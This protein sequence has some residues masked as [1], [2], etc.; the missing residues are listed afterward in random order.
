MFARSALTLAC[1]AGILAVGSL[2]VAPRDAAAEVGRIE[3]TPEFIQQVNA[4]IDRGVAFLRKAQLRE[5]GWPAY[6]GYGPA[7]TAFAYHTMRACGVPAT[8]PALERG[9][10]ALRDEWNG[11]PPPLRQTYTIALVMMAVAEHGRRQPTPDGERTTALEPADEAW[12]REMVATLERRQ[13]Q[14]GTWGYL[15]ASSRAD[16]TDNSNTQ[17]ALL[18]LKAAARCGVAIRSA[19]WRDALQHFVSSQET[20]GPAAFAGPEM[21]SRKGSTGSRPTDA[22]RGWGYT[23][24]GAAYGSMTAG[25][26]GSVV[27]CRSELVGTS[28]MP[29]GLDSRA[30]KS[31]RDG[32]AWLGMHFSVKT[33]PGPP[34]TM[35]GPGWH[36]YYLYAVE[37]AGVLAG[38]DWMGDRDWY[39]E[40]APLL[41][42][43]Q[44]PDGSWVQEEGFSGVKGAAVRTPHDVVIHTC[45][46]L[47]F[48]RKGTIPVRRG[49]LTKSADDAD[50]RFDG[51]ADLSVK[52]FDDLVDLVLQRWTRTTDADVRTRL[53]DRMTAVGPRIVAPLLQRMSSDDE[54]DRIAAH[55]L[56]R[57]A[58]GQDFGYDPKSARDRRED[59][60]LGWQGWWL[61]CEKT[62]KYDP[63]SRRLK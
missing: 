27:I 24:G 4:S 44:R 3:R 32:L 42:G 46:S 43:M 6:P 13:A 51:A 30:E 62:L 11:Y 61:G 63:A 21:T 60:I 5:G 15:G 59:A 25:A 50:I 1:L 18:G 57:R 35:A 9:Y 56:L 2:P 49:A 54:A 23:E 22:S 7:T 37:R 39:G 14:D 10:A 38:V 36:F 31:I 29:A 55:E 28:G 47:L 17:Y 33:N 19:T 52:D 20:Q 40:G 12:M 53:F 41:M 16:R 26:V 34:S 45:F 8:D 58:T 48:L